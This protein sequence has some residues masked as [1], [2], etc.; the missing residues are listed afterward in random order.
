MFTQILKDIV[1]WSNTNSG[2]LSL[3]I[4]VITILFGWLSGIFGSLR[5]RPKFKVE[6]IEGPS[7]CCTLNTGRKYNGHDTHRT[8]ISLYL[9]ITNIGTAASQIMD[10]HV[11]YHNFS[12]KYTFK[13]F[14][15]KQRTNSLVDFRINIGDHIKYYPFLTQVSSISGRPTDTFLEAG[16]SAVGM[17][18]FEQSEA[19]GGYRPRISNNRVRLKIVT[20]DIYNRHHSVIAFVPNVDLEEARKFNPEFGNTFES[21]NKKDN[22]SAA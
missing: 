19:W 3:I 10:I 6:V 20:V 4:F 2:F 15:L 16:K 21:L 12:F 9:S 14:W 7:L 22:E 11:G 8:V 13:W 1:E 5:R 18:Y 17:E